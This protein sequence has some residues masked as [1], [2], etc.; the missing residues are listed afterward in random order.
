M[1]RKS[2]SFVPG[3]ILPILICLMSFAWRSFTFMK[4]WLFVGLKS[5]MRF[6]KFLG[7]IRDMG[8]IKRFLSVKMLLS[9]KGWIIRLRR[10]CCWTWLSW[11]KGFI[12]QRNFIRKRVSNLLIWFRRGPRLRREFKRIRLSWIRL[13]R[14]SKSKSLFLMSWRLNI[15]RKSWRWVESRDMRLCRRLTNKRKRFIIWEGTKSQLSFSWK[16]I[17]ISH[18]RLKKVFPCLLVGIE[19]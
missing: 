1:T 18:F 16:K 4:F 7:R 14:S 8:I 2:I 3:K 11:L 12:L 17:R 6:F 10:S 9:I 19:Y 15:R 13:T 5:L